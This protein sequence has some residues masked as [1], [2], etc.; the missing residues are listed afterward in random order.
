MAAMPGCGTIVDL[1]LAVLAPGQGSQA[2]GMLVPWL[3][4]PGA[5]ERVAWLST[6]SGLNL[7]RLGT[8]AD[9]DEI[10][11]T[12]ITQPLIVA[13]GLLALGGLSLDSVPVVAGHSIGEITAATAA[14]ALT[15]ESA[16]ALAAVRGR[17][18]AAACRA[19]PT[20]MSAVLGGQPDDVLCRLAELGLEAANRNGPGQVVAAGPLD[21]LATLAADPPARSRVIPLAVAGAFHTR[22]MTPAREALSAVADG[23]TALDPEPL[24]LSNADGAAVSTGRG[25]VDR[26]VSQ[27]TSPVRWDLCQDTLA[28]LGVNAAIELPPA[29]TLVGLAK[30]HPVLRGAELLALKT[31]DDLPAARDLL[32]RSAPSAESHTPEWR[33][34]VSP[35]KGTFH[36]QGHTEGDHLVAGTPLGTIEGRRDRQPVSATYDSVLGEWI[37]VEGDLVAAGQPLALLYPGGSA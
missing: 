33:I 26:L 35:V 12:A 34:V 23:V 7:E 21:A 27:V 19:V 6:L 1:V 10:T 9:A 32:A 8:T 16:I 17:E 15:P 11:D 5:R 3:E 29:G 4:V 2:P 20:G 37:A 13:L 24:L 31:P 25:M 22:F 28:D 30:R 18:M 14:G 36:P